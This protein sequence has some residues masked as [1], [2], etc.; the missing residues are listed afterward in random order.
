MSLVILFFSKALTVIEDDTGP[1]NEGSAFYLDDSWIG[2]RL[3]Q[4]VHLRA[5]LQGVNDEVLLSGGDLHQAGEAQKTPVGMVLRERR[6]RQQSVS[7]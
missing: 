3:V 5:E 2:E 7:I 6:E 4:D 1:N